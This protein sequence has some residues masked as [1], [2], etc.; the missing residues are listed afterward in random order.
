VLAIMVYGGATNFIIPTVLSVMAV[1]FIHQAREGWRLTPWC[2]LAG[3]CLWAIPLSAIKLLPAFVF[4]HSYARPYIPSYLFD[5]PA[6]LLKVLAA[7][8]FAPAVLPSFIYPIRGSSYSLGLHEFEFGV[9][10]VPLLLILA[11]VPLLVR[12][13]SRPRHLFA[14]IGL[15]LVVA[16]PIVLTVGNE[17]WGRILLKIP[18]IN[19]NTTFVRWWSIYIMPVI[20]VA[21]LAF[22]RVLR[23]TAVRNVAL[24]AGVLIAVAQLVSRDLGYYQNNMLWGLYD[25]SQ[26]TQAIGRVAGGIPLPEISR[27]GPAPNDQ[28]KL[29][30]KL[31]N[32]GLVWG[33]STYPCYE[34]LFG[35]SLELFPAQELHAGPVKSDID[36]HFNLADPRC[37]LSVDLGIC[38]PGTLFRQDERLDVAKFI[39]HRALPWQLPFWQDLAEGAT[40]T[41]GSLSALAL[42]VLAVGASRQIKKAALL[43]SGPPAG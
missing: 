6:R 3:V 23:Y 13:A 20:I 22:D 33:I 14:W 38:A 42:F 9:S 1:L 10:I 32:D 18:I 39:S 27:L 28:P 36:G 2:M 30:A 34:A 35:Y 24:C 21:G 19:N 26:V 43:K 37:Y 8:L 29:D 40:I 4:A 31:N 7:S 5:D 25:P 41:A 16:I 12:N 15:A 11:A 17:A